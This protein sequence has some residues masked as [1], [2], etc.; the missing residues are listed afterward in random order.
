MP[1]K[2]AVSKILYNVYFMKFFLVIIIYFMSYLNIAV[3]EYMMYACTV[4]TTHS[5]RI[6]QK[7]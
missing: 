7:D 1:I 4:I 2:K 6:M 5:Q 3:V